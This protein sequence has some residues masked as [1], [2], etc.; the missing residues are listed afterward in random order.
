MDAN[1]PELC[2]RA[3]LGDLGVTM[4]PEFT[5]VKELREGSIVPILEKYTPEGNAFYAV[6]AH[7]RHVSTKVQGVCRFHGGMVQEQSLRMQTVKQEQMILKYSDGIS[8]RTTC[9]ALVRSSAAGGRKRASCLAHPHVFIEANL[10]V[11]RNDKGE[12]T[13][14]RHVWRFDELFS[15]SLFLDFDENGNGK[16]DENE[17]QEIAGITKESIAKYNFYTE[18]RNGERSSG[19]FMNLILILSI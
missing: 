8:R 13:E 3:V 18:I 9:G 10:E 5:I 12:A 16:L 6:Y 19:I 4:V 14:I 2:K 1:D 17:L 11:V 15:S 7:R